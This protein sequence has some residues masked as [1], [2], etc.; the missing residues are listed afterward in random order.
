MSN[1][2]F[3][4]ANTEGKFDITIQL[5]GPDRHL[6]PGLTAQVV[7]T[8]EKKKDVLYI[9]R[10]SLFMKDGKRVVYLKNGKGFEQRDVKVQYENESRAVVEGLKAN[11][12]VALLDPTIPRTSGSSSIRDLGGVT[13]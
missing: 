2:Q 3:W 6:R 13:R 12:R 7:I 11:N 4:E 1:R 10:Q 9:P 8:G 5:S